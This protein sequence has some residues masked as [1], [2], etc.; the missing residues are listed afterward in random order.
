[1]AK[2]LFAILQLYTVAMVFIHVSATPSYDFMASSAD[3]ENGQATTEPE[4]VGKL[5]LITFNTEKIEGVYHSSG[6]GGIRFIS[7]AFG[8]S[9]YLSIRTLNGEL[10]MSVN[11]QS[12]VATLMTIMGRQ[13]LILNHTVSE[14]GRYLT[15]FVVPADY[16]Q[17][18]SESLKK[19]QIPL[20]ILRHL[21]FETA[22]TTRNDA[23]EELLARPEVEMIRGVIREFAIKRIIGAENLPAMTIYVLAMRLTKFQNYKMELSS[24]EMNPPAQRAKRSHCGSWWSSSQKQHCSNSGKCCRRCPVGP[25]CRGMCGPGCHPAWYWWGVCGSW[26]YKQGCYDHDICC[27]NWVSWGCQVPDSSFSCDGGYNCYRDDPVPHYILTS[28][29]RLLYERIRAFLG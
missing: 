28:G 4:E 20:K 29:G 15:G 19:H 7:E 23:M 11:R 21:E 9:R 14:T 1:M 25:Q 24:D 3:G 6:G 2:K 26:C 12:E 27:Q 13:F 16:S 17:R 5:D 22:N 18:L 8:E 10:L